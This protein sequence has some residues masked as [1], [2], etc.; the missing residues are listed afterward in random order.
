MRGLLRSF[1]LSLRFLLGRR[2][3]LFLAVDALVLV[4]A[5]WAMLL[6]SSGDSIQVYRF[7]FLVPSLVL[8]LPALAGIVD[9]ERR[10]G[11]L[12]L[13][14]SAPGAEAYFVR[15]AGAVAALAAAQGWLLVLLGWLTF[16]RSFPLLP[17]LVQTAVVSLFLAAVSLFWAVR[18]RKA[19]A[20][21]LASAVTALA[22]GRWLFFDPTAPLPR[23]AP[24]L[25]FP[26]LELALPWLESAGVLGAGAALFYLYA[27]GRLRRPERLLS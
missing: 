1:R 13:A 5:L 14:L 4:R 23:A 6:S 19:G 24:R 26:S 16:D 9:L 21:W 10:A 12:D 3:G 22:A 7:L 11:C 25:F 18:L 27:R 20:V 8:A 17:P 2:L 15:R